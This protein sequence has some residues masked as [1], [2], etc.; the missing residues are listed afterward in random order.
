MAFPGSS[1][2]LYSL[3][4]DAFGN[5]QGAS[6]QS[7]LLLACFL[8]SNTDSLAFLLKRPFDN[9][10]PTKT[11]QGISLSQDSEFGASSLGAELVKNLPVWEAWV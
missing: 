9:A 10:V 6:L 7:L 5:L 4:C 8:L 1:G 2:C 11:I 3:F